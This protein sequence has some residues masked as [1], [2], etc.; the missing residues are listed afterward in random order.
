V[1]LDDAALPRTLKLEGAMA[2]PGSALLR[3]GDGRE[4]LG[5]RAL[6]DAGD[7]RAAAGSV[8]NPAWRELMQSIDHGL[9]GRVNQLVDVSQDK[10]HYVVYSSPEARPGEFYLG[11]RQSGRLD[12]LASTYPALSNAASPA[13]HDER[14]AAHDGRR[15]EVSITRPTRLRDGEAAPM[16]VIPEPGGGIRN[17]YDFDHW[18]AFLADRGYAVLQ[19]RPGASTSGLQRSG[20]QTQDDLA[21][22]LQWAQKQ[23]GVDAKRVCIVGAGDGGHAALMGLVKSPD[24]YRCGVSIAAATDLSGFLLEQ[25]SYRGG[26]VA[27]ERMVGLPASD[28]ERLRALSPAL[29]AASIRA[30]VLLVHGTEDRLMPFDQGQEMADALRKADKPYRFIEQEGGDH[31]LDDYPRRLQFFTELERFLDENLKAAVA[32]Q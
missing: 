10:T 1:R 18:A 23:G 7:S 4:V 21:D 29:Q 28:R 22:A 24:R 26:L 9:P 19:L 17:R 2:H 16:V 31:G 30:P 5:L 6:S 25:S 15:I 8:W 27:A 20:T 32:P 12:F 13:R 14:I 11:D 3:D